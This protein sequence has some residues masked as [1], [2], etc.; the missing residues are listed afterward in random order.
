M[1]TLGFSVQGGS[2]SVILGFSTDGTTIP[3]GTNI[4]TVLTL[5]ELDP[6]TL[7]CI[8]QVVLSDELGAP[9]PSSVVCNEDDLEVGNICHFS[10]YKSS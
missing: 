1:A 2:N 9:L 7:I 10:F 3:V 5:P 6:G 8:D 4:L